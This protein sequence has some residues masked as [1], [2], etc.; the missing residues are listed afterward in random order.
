MVIERCAIVTGQSPAG[1]ETIPLAADFS[2][3]DLFRWAHTVA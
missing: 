2:A 3:V 1:P